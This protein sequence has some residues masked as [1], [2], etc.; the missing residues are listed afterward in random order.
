MR[1][2]TRIRPESY[3]VY[4]TSDGKEFY[5][6]SRA[7]QYEATLM[8][9]KNIPNNYIYLYTHDED[10][11][12]YCYKIESE[13]DLEC[14]KAI[15]WNYNAVWDYEGPGWYVAFR[16]DGGD[17]ADDYSVSHIQSYIHYLKHDL[18]VLEELEKQ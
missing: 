4:I 15:E 3:T 7:R 13:K 11:G 10:I 9:F 5:N 6:E 18:S 16:H 14:L 12:C 1:E 17:Y 2:E 8:P